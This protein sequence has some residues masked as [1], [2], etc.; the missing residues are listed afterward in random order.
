[1]LLAIAGAAEPKATAAGKDADKFMPFVELAPFVVQGKQLA[2]SIYARSKGD[3]R[4]AEAFAEEVVKVVYEGVN[5]ETGKGLVIIGKKGEPHPVFVFRKFLALAKDGKLDPAVAAR[6]PELFTMLDHWKQTVGEGEAGGT[7][8]QPEVDVQFEKIVTALPL[9]LEGIGA[10]LYQLAWAEDF[11]DARV[12]AKLRSLRAPDLEGN[13]FAHFDWV[14]YL[15]PRGVFESAID[16]IIADALKEENAGFFERTV[17]KSAMLVVKPSIRKMIE[18]MRRSV[19]FSAVV[20]ARA[21]FA[22]D[23]VAVLT[24][25]YMDALLN[26]HKDESGSEHERAVRAVRAKVR[27]FEEKPSPPVPDHAEEPAPAAAGHPSQAAQ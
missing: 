15:P 26:E 25:A 22:P 20:Q 7:N 13:L 3:R 17:V 6:G 1:L 18:G 5:P 8:G 12:E 2:I 16:G 14:F 4:Y 27:S 19:M 23:E 9:P 24:G 21:P 10:K 11:D